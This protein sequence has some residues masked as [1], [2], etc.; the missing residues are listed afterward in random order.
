MKNIIRAGFLLGIV[1]SSPVTVAPSGAN[2]ATFYLDAKTGNGRNDGRTPKKAWQSL[3]V[4][5][6]KAI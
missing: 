6:S 2:A 4:A 3:T 1:A 5:T